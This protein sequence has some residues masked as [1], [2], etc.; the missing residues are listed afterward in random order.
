M[1]TQ[2]KTLTLLIFMAATLFSCSKKSD[3]GTQPLTATNWTFG[4]TTYK[5]TYTGI[6]NNDLIAND[7]AITTFPNIEMQF[8]S[9]PTAGTYTVINNLTD[10]GTIGSTQ[11]YIN[12]SDGNGDYE[13]Y[14]YNGGTVT[15]TIN[16]G[17]VTASFNNIGMATSGFDNNNNLVFT[18]TGKVSGTLIQQ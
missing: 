9:T 2:I 15:V 5:G 14:S 4:G 18:P 6:T 8:G 3:N 17:K 10:N 12:M 11:C 1:K 16:N 7:N 13:Y